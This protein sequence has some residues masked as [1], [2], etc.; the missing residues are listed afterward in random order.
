M[1]F[2]RNIVYYRKQQKITQEELADRLYVSRQTVSRWE[3]DS[4]FPD[5]ETTIKLCEL[6]GCNM[7]ILV[8][9]NA[10][11][12]D[13]KNISEGSEPDVKS[14][15]S[16]DEKNERVKKSERRSRIAERVNETICSTVF[17]LAVFSYVIYGLLR[18]VWHPTWII[19][20][21]AVGI[22]AI[23]SVITEAITR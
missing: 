8:R 12:D 15:N 6:F 4:V 5:I 7:D 20:V 22:C 1:S 16:T 19:F 18:G 23:S 17:T 13:E 21:V 10:E 9:G 14:D 3:N 2:G 11:E